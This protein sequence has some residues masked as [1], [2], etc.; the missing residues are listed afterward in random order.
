MNDSNWFIWVTLNLFV[1][2]L[3]TCIK[4]AY[5]VDTEIFQMMKPQTI[6]FYFGFF[7]SFEIRQNRSS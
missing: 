3:F 7:D 5:S 6:C 2:D 1:D 4:Y